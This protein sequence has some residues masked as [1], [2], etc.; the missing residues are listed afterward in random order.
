MVELEK[1]RTR[2]E[3]L[4]KAVMRSKVMAAEEGEEGVEKEGGNMRWWVLLA[5]EVLIETLF[6]IFKLGG[7]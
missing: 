3:G 4:G 6:E 5:K 7:A 1:Q 2:K